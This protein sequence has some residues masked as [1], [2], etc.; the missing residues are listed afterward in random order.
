MSYEAELAAIG[1]R[2]DDQA[3]THAVLQQG[4]IA[5]RDAAVGKVMH[6][7]AQIAELQAELDTF[8]PKWTRNGLPL[9]GQTLLGGT[10][11][12]PD[13]GVVRRYARGGD[14]PSAVAMGCIADHAAGAIPWVSFKL[15]VSWDSA[16]TGGADVW[17]QAMATELGKL[18]GPVWIAIHHE[19]E[20]DGDL[21]TWV[22]IQQ[23][24]MPYFKAAGSNIATSIILMG[25][26][27]WL[28]TAGTYSMDKCWPGAAFVDIVGFDPYNFYD[29]TKS[30]TTTK[31]Y[32]WDELSA[33]YQPI[34]A[35]L[36]ARGLTDTVRWAIAETAISDSAFTVAQ[37]HK[38][39]N[40]KTVATRGPGSQ[41]LARAYD[42]MKAAGGIALTYFNVAGTVNSEP[43]DWTWPLSGQKLAAFQTLA[44]RADRRNTEST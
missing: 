6:L 21:A 15:P 42:D 31:N 22:R 24:L 9:A 33:Y 43:G 10:V 36:Q 44:A 37:G 19:P 3:A 16:A 11:G 34:R 1:K 41:W 20:G 28:S 17:A 7:E 18:A 23:R 39:P 13:V 14:T 35:W 5:E 40:G 8:R 29:T 27:Q 38:A 4:W 30:G 12:T 2:A 32:A 25:W 26:H